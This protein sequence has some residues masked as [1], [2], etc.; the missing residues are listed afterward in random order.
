MTNLLTKIGT[1]VLPAAAMSLSVFGLAAGSA[2]QSSDEDSPM[3]CEISITKDRFGHTYKGLVHADATVEGTYELNISKRGGG[4]TMISQAGTF[5]IPAGK[6][7]SL[8]QA[9]FGGM[10][11]QSV[12]AELVLTVDGKKYVC[13]TD[14]EI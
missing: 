9:T 14:A 1:F 7:Q 2:A 12:A 6:T 13:G 11:P 3:Q 8:G 5:R 4:L 10:P